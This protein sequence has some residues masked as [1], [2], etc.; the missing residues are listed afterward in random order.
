MPLVLPDCVTWEK[1]EFWEIS[2]RYGSAGNQ[3]PE[4]V[5][6]VH[7][8]S[9]LCEE[10]ETDAGSN[11]GALGATPSTKNDRSMIEETKFFEFLY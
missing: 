7:A 3:E 11:A 4:S 8:K 10:P 5:V 2:Y 6:G 1:S 9:T